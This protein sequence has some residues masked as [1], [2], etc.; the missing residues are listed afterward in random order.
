MSDNT[1]LIEQL[2][3]KVASEL[4]PT[5]KAA[6]ATTVDLAGEA[7]DVPQQAQARLKQKVN[8]VVGDCRQLLNSISV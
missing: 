1:D 3:T 4:L 8:A 5:V 6:E 2:Q 7:I